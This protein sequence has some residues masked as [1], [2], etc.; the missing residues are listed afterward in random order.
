MVM[1]Q[2]RDE[3]LPIF[4]KPTNSFPNRVETDY[5]TLRIYRTVPYLVEIN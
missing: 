4:K 2:L 5:H 1:C 3:S